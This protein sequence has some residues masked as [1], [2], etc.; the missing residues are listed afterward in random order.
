MGTMGHEIENGDEGD[1]HEERPREPWGM[2]GVLVEGDIAG[3]DAAGDDTYT[4]IDHYGLQGIDIIFAKQLEYGRNGHIHKDGDDKVLQG[5]EC[6]LLSAVFGVP[7]VEQLLDVAYHGIDL[8]IIETIVHAADAPKI[9]D[10]YIVIIVNKIFIYT[11]ACGIISGA[12]E[13][14]I[15]RHIV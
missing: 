5:A 8:V 14:A 4:I 2:Q 11:D 3:E 12:N 1:S 13:V 15:A 10:Q 7:F 6:D 9:V